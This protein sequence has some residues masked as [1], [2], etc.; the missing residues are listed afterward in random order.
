MTQF[1]TYSFQDCEFSLVGPGGAISLKD[2][3]S[4]EGIKIAMLDDKDNMLIG[5]N[6]SG[7][8]S[9]HAGK[10]GTVE[11][12]LLRNSTTNS[13]LS[14]MYNLQQTSST[15]WGQNVMV[16]VTSTGDAITCTG[17]AFKKQPDI[18]YGKDG[19]MYTWTFNFIE[20]NEVLVS[21]IV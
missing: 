9:L 6:G 5:A 11:V 14:V 8:H 7:M 21:N 4:E 15:L 18:S 16:V 3:A 13:L 20:I 1:K 2:G 17:G 10:S 12:S 19:G